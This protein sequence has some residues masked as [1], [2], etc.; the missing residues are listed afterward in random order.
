MASFKTGDYIYLPRGKWYRKILGELSD[1]Y[2]ALNPL[3]RPQVK[4]TIG[5][6]W[7]DSAYI[8]IGSSEEEF[9]LY[10]LQRELNNDI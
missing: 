5:K 10:L 3:E 9:K 6:E 1:T 7:S 8:L 4:R 2:L